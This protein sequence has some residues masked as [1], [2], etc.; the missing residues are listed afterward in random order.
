[1][2]SMSASAQYNWS[3][4]LDRLRRHAMEQ[5]AGVSWIARIRIRILEFLLARY[6]TNL[7]EDISN[8]DPRKAARFATGELDAAVSDD[9]ALPRVRLKE[10][11]PVR[12]ESP[13]R[14]GVSIRPILNHLEEMHEASERARWAPQFY[15]Q[16]WEWWAASSC[17][18]LID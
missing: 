7:A 13:A 1:M 16:A 3:L 4:R 8:R 10:I 6:S 12:T 14:S 5:P 15:D 17:R 9:F 11:G 2:L 18:R